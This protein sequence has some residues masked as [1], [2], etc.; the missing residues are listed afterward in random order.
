MNV[1]MLKQ[2]KK[3]TDF[4]GS[5]LLNQFYR[6]CGKFPD[7]I[8]CFNSIPNFCKPMSNL[9]QRETL[10]ISNICYVPRKLSL[11]TLSL[12]ILLFKKYL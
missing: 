6:F 1:E 10:N 7:A 3:R 12:I 5:I 2:S 11:T 4:K 9:A 8:Y